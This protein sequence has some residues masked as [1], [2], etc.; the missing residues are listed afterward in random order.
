MTKANSTSSGEPARPRR[1]KKRAYVPPTLIAL[2]HRQD[3]RRR[4]WLKRILSAPSTPLERAFAELER[5]RRAGAAG[6]PDDTA[7]GKERPT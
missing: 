7:D 6:A 3:R 1:S 4:D 5:R 2:W